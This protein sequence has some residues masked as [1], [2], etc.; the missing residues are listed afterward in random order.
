MTVDDLVEIEAIKR[1]KYAYLRCLDLKLWDELAPLFTEDAVCTYSSGAYTYEG[2]DAILGFL[3]AAMDRTTFLSSHKV[4]HPE[5]T[6]TGST[7]ARGTWGLEDTVI[8]LEHRI[9]IRGCAFYEDEYV[10]QDGSWRFA[11]TGYRRVFEEVER[12]PAPPDLT[13]TASWWG[14]DGRSSLPAPS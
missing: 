2:R 11:R 14:S 10:R 7:T 3:R 12:R 4:H 9:T 5:I 1:L 13:L 8:D 6:L